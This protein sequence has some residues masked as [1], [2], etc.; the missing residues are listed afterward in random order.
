[1]KIALH[2]PD[3]T[4]FPNY[5]LMKISAWHK[6]IGDTVTWFNAIER[7]SYKTIYSS[8][9]FTQRGTDPYLPEN[10]IYGGTGY[11]LFDSQLSQDIDNMFPDY[12]IYPNIDY[13]IGFLTRGC[14]RSCP[15]CVVPKK[16]GNIHAYR[17][18]RDIVRTDTNKVILMDNNVLA[19]DFGIFQINELTKTNY[20][21]DFNQGLDARLI[22]PAIAKLLA[23]IKWIRCIRLACDSQEMKEPV[24]RAVNYL[25]D[26]GLKNEIFVYVLVQDIDDALVD[27]VEFL[28][29]IKCEPFAQPYR[30]V[31]TGTEPTQKQKNFARWVNHKAIFK[32][33]KWEEYKQNLL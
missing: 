16:E 30:N 6:K 28:R 19:S 33:V 10:T 2:T 29:N 20:R 12:S 31:L 5:A 17:S 27:R 4:K 21:I 11:G 3:K 23:Q 8:S 1:M 13:A 7:D 25:R 9:V 24:Q 18:W 22:A 26:A 15:W 14:I 32:T